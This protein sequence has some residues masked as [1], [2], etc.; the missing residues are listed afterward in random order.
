M[1]RPEPFN[2]VAIGLNGTRLIEASAGTGKTYSI[3]LLFLRLV[4]EEGI[5]LEEILVVTYTRAATAELKGR[6]RTFLRMAMKAWRSDEAESP[7]VLEIVKACRER[8]D[9]D[10]RLESLRTALLCL[11][12]AAIFTIHGFC[13]RVLGDNAFETGTAYDAEMVTDQDDFIAEVVL[14]FYRSRISSAPRPV[15]SCLRSAS[16]DIGRLM[17]FVK[18]GLNHQLLKADYPRDAG[19]AAAMKVWDRLKACWDA[20]SAEIMDML[21]APGVLDRRSDIYKT[22]SRPGFSHNLARC[23][24]GGLFSLI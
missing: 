6:I 18:T 17:K 24:S 14:D 10:K 23:F 7:D 22:I 2:A 1:T 16:M 11:D 4:L 19:P 15:F 8:A 5:P 21:S 9:A 13:Q 12:E 20:S 3:A